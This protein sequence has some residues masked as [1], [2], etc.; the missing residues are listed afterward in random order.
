MLDMIKKLVA[1]SPAQ[2]RDSALDA[3]RKAQSRYAHDPS[4]DNERALEDAERAHRLADLRARGAD[5]RTARAEREEQEK[6]RAADVAAYEQAVE[7][8]GGFDGESFPALIAGE[9]D[10][11][12]ALEREAASIA[13]TM[14]ARLETSR[15]AAIKANQLAARVGRPPVTFGWYEGN[16]V[17]TVHR[18]IRDARAQE[19]RHG[20]AVSHWLEA[21]D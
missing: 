9:V 15:R 18:A 7:A 19:G 16:V 5:E 12:V 21:H 2:Q 3:L 8:A 13:Q 14:L 4:P 17:G 1:P 10:R 11:L 20:P 6:R